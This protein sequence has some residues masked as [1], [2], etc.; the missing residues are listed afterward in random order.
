MQTVIQV[1]CTRGG[2]LRERIADDASLN[3]HLLLVVKELQPGRSPGWMKLRS[4]ETDRHGAINIEWD[5]G[6]S[7]LTCR[8]VTRNRGKP[9]RIIG[10]FLEYL[11]ARHRRRVQS[12]TLAPR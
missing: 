11:L 10:D 12:V 9:D 7:I 8:V 1:Y 4:T 6:T 3:K 2:S 5:A